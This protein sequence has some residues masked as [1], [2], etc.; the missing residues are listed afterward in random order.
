MKL[1]RETHQGGSLATEPRAKGAGWTYRWRET[2]PDGKRVKRKI[3]VGTVKVLKSK[4]MAKKALEAM[5]ANIHRYVMRLESWPPAWLR[6]EESRPV[7]GR[8]G[9]ESDNHPCLGGLPM[10]SRLTNS[11]GCWQ[12]WRN[13][14]GRWW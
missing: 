2:A 4:G 12:R 3:I 10:C 6:F 5:K 13:P 7:K 14:F 1:T 8:G 9:A 11:T